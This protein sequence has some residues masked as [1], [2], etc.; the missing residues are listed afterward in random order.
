MCDRYHSKK[1]CEQAYFYAD[2][3]M[4]KKENFFEDL[5]TGMKILDE[6][7]GNSID[8]EQVNPIFVRRKNA[9]KELIA[10]KVGQETMQKFVST[11]LTDEDVKNIFN[12]CANKINAYKKEVLEEEVMK[13]YE[14]HK[15][16]IKRELFDKDK[17]IL[18][19][20]HGKR[21]GVDGIEN[22]YLYF[23]KKMGTF[24][25]F[26]DG[27]SEVINIGEYSNDDVYYTIETN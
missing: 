7:L 24:N 1:G 11:C 26:S 12:T 3:G 17:A 9:I 14:A 16:Q 10:S 13:F 4:N 8:F 15:D 20:M 2:K 19:M 5:V 25:K 23:S 18:E 21:V 6:I 27:K 22:S